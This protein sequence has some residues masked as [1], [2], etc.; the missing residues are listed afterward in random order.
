M[1][2][3]DVLPSKLARAFEIAGVCVQCAATDLIWRGLDL[4]VVDF[5]DPLRRA[6][7]TRKQSFAYTPL[8]QQHNLSRNDLYSLVCGARSSFRTLE[9]RHSKLSPTRYDSALQ[10]QP[11]EPEIAK[12]SRR[13]KEQS[14]TTGRQP[15]M[16]QHKPQK[17][18]CQIRLRLRFE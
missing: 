1:E 7:H 17:P 10:Q 2:S 15:N 8:E 13:S 9:Q 3:R 14:Q 5:Q 12:Q 11:R 18:V 4:E 16:P 6:I